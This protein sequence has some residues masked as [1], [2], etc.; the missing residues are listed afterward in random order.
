[1]NIL[2]YGAG[3]SGKTELVRSVADSIGAR[4]YGLKNP[5]R[6]RL[7]GEIS[8]ILQ[9]YTLL[10]Q[11]E[12]SLMIIEN[13]DILAHHE[14]QESVSY[15]FGVNSAPV[16]WVAE[17]LTHMDKFIHRFSYCLRS[18]RF[19]GRDIKNILQNICS[20]N[21]FA[22]PEKSIDEIATKYDMGPGV[23]TTA[24]KM[25]KLPKDPSSKFPKIV[26]ENV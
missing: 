20:R 9:A 16:I 21:E 6:S 22:A 2:I 25:A 15:L 12:R 10:A 4:L 26:V 24:V 7:G 1:M 11:S 18:D 5:G 23:L 13:A 14:N 3:G 17:S 19:S 8:K